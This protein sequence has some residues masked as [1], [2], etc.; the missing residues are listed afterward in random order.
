MINQILKAVLLVLLVTFVACTAKKEETVI[1]PV[2]KEQ[3][4][5]MIQDKENHYAELYTK[6]DLGKIDYYADDAIVF[7]QNQKMLIGKDS[8]QAYLKKG[9]EASSP[10]NKIS[11]ITD[12][13]YVFNDANQVLEIGSFRLVDSVDVL[14]NSGH[15]MILFEKRD[16]KYVSV[17]EMSTSD[18]ELE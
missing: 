5:K 2:D 17:R 1:A 15:Y 12:D 6:G 18:I 9:L 3:I 11:F 14:I 7:A 4:K 13:V 10:G 16:G 8:I